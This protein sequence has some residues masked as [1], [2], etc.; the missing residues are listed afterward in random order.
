M[1]INGMFSVCEIKNY[2]VPQRSVSGPLILLLNVND[3]SSNINTREKVNHFA[4]N[5][6][7]F[8]CGKE[9]RLQEPSIY[10]KTQKNM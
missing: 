5:T 9:S 3:F 2:G 10:Y 1:I 4:I 7:I 6:I 8:C